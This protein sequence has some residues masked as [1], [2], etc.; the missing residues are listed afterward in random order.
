MNDGASLALPDAPTHF[1]QSLE[2]AEDFEVGPGVLR[3][4]LRSGDE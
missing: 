3:G 1:L 2:A 4:R